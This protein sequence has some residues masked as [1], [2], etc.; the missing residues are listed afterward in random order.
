MWFRIVNMDSATKTARIDIYDNIGEFKD[1]WTGETSGVAARDFSNSLSAL[2]DVDNI[3]LH[4][5]SPGG[6]VTD[7]LQIY[8]ELKRHSAQI[9]VIIDG[10]AASIAS[11]IA[12]A[13]DEVVMP[14]NTSLFVHSPSAW[15]NQWLAGNSDELR[16][17]A[18]TA[19]SMADDLDTIEGQL[20]NVYLAKAQA[21]QTTLTAED[22]TRMMGEETLI[23]AT[24]AVE[25]GLA[26]TLEDPL[27]QAAH[28][29]MTQW[30]AQVEQQVSTTAKTSTHPPKTPPEPE[31][32]PM[33]ASEVVTTCQQA[34]FKHL[35][36]DLIGSQCTAELVQERLQLAQQIKDISA[37][38]NIESLADQLIDAAIDSPV[39]AL[40]MALG[41]ILEDGEAHIDNSLR[42]PTPTVIDTQKIYAE[43][44]QRHQQP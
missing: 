16:E 15:V 20:V 1:W 42:T 30:R 35:A 33:A 9:K 37:A 4:I 12:M 13:G 28:V 24:Q 2:G 40:Q 34:G 43:R 36:V 25:W 22:F 39:K 32:T 17:A 10:Q 6:S 8:N 41:I 7:G 29:D 44:N 14:E 21:N 11:I 26:D 5:N 27:Q 19:L 3:E 23:T 38:A 31:A 18:K